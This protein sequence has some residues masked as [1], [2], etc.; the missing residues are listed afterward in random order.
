MGRGGRGFPDGK[1]RQRCPVGERTEFPSKPKSG[2]K[3]LPRLTPARTY[4]H[5]L[6][7]PGTDFGPNYFPLG[8]S[9]LYA[10]PVE[11]EISISASMIAALTRC[12]V[13]I[14][15]ESHQ[16]HMSR[17]GGRQDHA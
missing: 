7:L 13:V 12:V 1:W 8:L 16:A 3:L 14:T 15:P 10:K 2:P 4:T 6:L 11:E 9:L 5:V 17:G